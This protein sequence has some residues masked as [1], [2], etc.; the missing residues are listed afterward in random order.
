[1]HRVWG[2]I[3]F[4]SLL[5]PISNLGQC[6][7]NVPI[8]NVDL[9]GTPDSVWTSPP[10]ARDGHCCG[11]AGNDRCIDFVV[12]LDPNAAGIS[13]D[14]ISGAVPGGALFYQVNCG[15]PTPVG[16]P[17]CLNGPGPHI[18]TF[19]KPGN[20]TNVYQINSIPGPVAGT[21]ITIND[22]CS[23]TLVA[24]GFEESTA[25]WNSIYPGSSGQ[26]NNYLSC[27][28]GCL[29]PTVTATGSN[30]P[31]Y[32]DYVVCGLPESECAS[33]TVCDTVRVTFNPSLAVNITP[34]DPVICFGAT[35]TTITAN[36]SGGT[37][38]Y[39]YLWNNV[40]PS[41]T[42]IVGAGTYTVQ[43]SDASGC[44]PTFA[45]VTVTTYANPIS[46]NAGPN[47]TLCIQS[48]LAS[49]N[50]SVISATGGV[51]S[52]G[53]GIFSPNDS[54]LTNLTYTP[55]TS[56]LNNG[57]V[58]LFLTTTGNGG[59][60]GDVD[61]VRISFLN[62]TGIPSISSTN[63]SCY[64][65][66]D[67][68]ATINV[69]G[70][71]TPYTYQWN[72]VPT[73][74]TQTISS[75]SAGDYSVTVTDGIGCTITDSTLIT[76]PLPLNSTSTS[77]DVTCFGGSDGTITTTSSGGTT[78]YSYLWSPGGQTTNSLSGLTAGNYSYTVTDTNGCSFQVFD[79]INQPLQ[80]TIT[81][82][83]TNVSC[84][85][86]SDG[87][88]T[89][90][91]NNPSGTYTYSWSPSG[92]NSSTASGLTAGTYTV[93][94]TSSFG[95]VITNTVTITE[96]AT[97]VSA[98]ISSTDVTCYNGNNGSATVTPSGG[99]SPYNYLW[100]GGQTTA[101]I[102]NLIAGTYNYQVTDTNGCS[103]S[104][105]VTITQPNQLIVSIS[106]QPVKCFGGSDGQAISY[107]SG[108]VAPYT[109]SWSPG[110]QT[111]ANLLNVT[112]GTYN[113]T[114]TDNN[115]CTA[116][117]TIQV[118]EPAAPLNTILT[119]TSTTCYGGNDGTITTGTTG[120]TAPYS[121]QWL[122]NGETTP[123]IM[124]DSGIYNVMITDS[125]G[126]TFNQ[127]A[128]ITQPTPV[129]VTFTT[130]NVSCYGGFDGSITATGGGGSSVYSYSW[131]QLGDTVQT[132]TG[133][134][135]GTYIVYVKDKKNCLAIDSVT[136]TQPAFPISQTTSSTPTSCF[137]SS[138]GTASVTPAGGTAAYT[139]LWSTGDI[140][141]TISG[142]PAGNY[143]VTITDANGCTSNDTATINQPNDL[144]IT[145]TNINNVSCFGGNDGSAS[146]SATGGTPNYSFSWSPN[147]NTSNTATGLSAGSYTVNVTDANGC[148][149]SNGINVTEPTVITTTY[150]VTNVSCFNGNNGIISTTPSGGTPPFTYSWMPG[151]LSG[152]TISGLTAG[153]YDL[154]LT[155][156]NGCIFTDIITITQPNQIILNSG[157]INSDCGQANGLAFVDVVSGGV[158]PF[159]YFWTPGNIANDTAN[160][161][162]SGTYNVTVTD[163]NGCNAYSVGNVNDNAAPLISITNTNVTCNGG[164][165]GT[166]S[167]SLT[168]GISP[169]TYS[170]SNGGATANINN[171]TAGIYYLTAGGANGCF[172]SDTITITEPT[173]ITASITTTGTLCNGDN[174]GTAT[175]TSYGG[176][177]GYSYSW[178]GSV[179]TTNSAA[180]LSA[181]SQNVTITDNSGCSIV[182]NFTITE[183]AILTTTT[184]TTDVSCFG[185]S[186][187][188]ATTVPS[189]GTGPY[190]FFWPTNNVNYATISNVPPGSYSVNITD[191]N[192]C[193]TSDNITINQPNQISLSI[194]TVNSTCGQANGQATVT[195]TGGTGGY[196][197][198]WIPSGGTAS[199]ETGLLSG[200]YTV[201]VFD[202]NNCISTS[203][204]TVNNIAG[205][206]T[207][208][209][210]T[211][212]V[213]CYGGSNGSATATP[214]GGTSPFTYLWSNG[215]TTATASSLSFGT[216]SVTVTDNNGCTSNSTTPL[217]NE[218]DSLILN[219]VTLPVS[220]YNGNDGSASATA[221][222]GTPGYSYSWSPSGST[223]TNISGISAGT[224]TVQVTD[225]K[226]CQTSSSFTITQ[227]SALGI[228][229][230]VTTD[231]NCLGGHDGTATV[232]V[233]GGTPLY[234]YNWAP[235][236][237]SGSTST[238][239]TA[240]NYTVTIT[241]QK[242][243]TITSSAT[244]NEP[245][246]AISATISLVPNSCAGGSNG[247]ATVTPSGGT[248]GYTYIWSISGASG[249]TASNLA[250]G[251]YSVAVYDTNN[252]RSNL[253]FNI[254]EPPGLVAS[255]QVTPPSCSL[256][257]GQLLAQVS[258]GTP[259]YIFNWSNSGS[260]SSVTGLAPG[261]YS[262]DITDNAGCSLTLDTT[263]INIP[264]PTMSLLS[265]TE[266]SCFGSNDG[267]AEVTLTNGTAPFTY[268]WSPF[269]GNSSVGNNL[270]AGIYS[271]V[272]TDSLNCSDTLNV[273]I[274]Q[275]SLLNVYINSIQDISCNGY[276][277]GS[278]T[279]GVSGGTSSYS[280]NWS[281]GS[282]TPNTLNN[283]TSG[284]YSVIVTDN[285]NC[286]DSIPFTINEPTP[287]VALVDSLIPTTCNGSQDGY[288]YVLTSGGTLP[289]SY[290]WSNGGTGNSISNISAGTY[291]TN[292]TDGNG[293]TT[294]ISANVTE[295]S[296]II[297][298]IVGN[299]T[300]CQGGLGTLSA[301]ATGGAGNYSFAWQPTAVVNSG[302]YSATPTSTTNYTV[303]AYDVNGCPGTIDTATIYV[304]SLGPE[305]IQAQ[306]Y[307]PICPGQSTVVYVQT[308]NTGDSLL[309]TWNN[310]LGTGMGGFVVE[311]TVPTSYVVTVSNLC[312]TSIT[313]TVDV[314]FNDPP[315]I[316]LGSDITNGCVPIS[317]HFT[318]SSYS[319][320]PLDPIVSWEWSFGD[321]TLSNIQNPSHDYNIAG[322]YPVT[323]TVTTLGGCTNNNSSTPY[324]I[325]AYP[326][327]IANFT[328]N[329]N[330][331]NIPLDLLECTN[332]SVGGDS[333]YWNFGD[334]QTSEDEN[335]THNYTSIGTFN[336]ELVTV[337]QY[338]CSDTTETIIITGSDLIFPNAF[339][340]N[341]DGSSG[342]Y[343]D[344]TSLNND[345]FFPYTSGV[346]EYKLQIFNR[347]GE[348]IFESDD[349]YKGW[350][351]YYRGKLVQQ[352]VYVW[353]AYVRLNTGKVYN[354]IGDVTVLR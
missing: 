244:I 220:C 237:G 314:V 186:N 12:T 20:N 252:C 29:S 243:C 164:N 107:T 267:S 265:S 269:G 222:G 67:G 331:L 256:N 15:P 130:T 112:A 185:G 18:I 345:I 126:C 142:Q 352:D 258:G 251:T 286:K 257:N 151:N 3:L 288:I 23:Q 99:T 162:F 131:P 51:W 80:A 284:S 291:N 62:F 28:S 132:V 106:Q 95:C 201:N 122:P 157:A 7:P 72:T 104:G 46:A 83:S 308:Y 213:S 53:N 8:F 285:H 124:G 332:T 61:T 118:T 259:S 6:G 300:I 40:N 260:N 156:S 167:A 278:I 277:D 54:S 155:D 153:T 230:I 224:G 248:P 91:I 298:S 139:Y 169:Y 13:L 41:Q 349:V 30:I 166:A 276:N 335:P 223:G 68:S 334:G 129:T 161:L 33:I 240:G 209:T 207:S 305:N 309:F 172:S 31:T 35:S 330:T 115:G 337:N 65:L 333:F 127:T 274:S 148:T 75:L 143:P 59:C 254:L 253:S 342:G 50:G 199:T 275:P 16:E 208:I 178:S 336:V 297:T 136:I 76:Q 221:H 56:E 74:T 108:G 190:S 210:A 339:T 176:N 189:G 181:G 262:V 37:P 60:P 57:F 25:S 94:A 86:G 52:G 327:P 177:P 170:W 63:I 135:A 100:A 313:D 103:T 70:G 302:L 324:L 26:Y 226:G 89:A 32:I 96:P 344:V 48:P 69:S 343:Y 340:P 10:V 149:T 203:S 165:N 242:G 296:P 97:P 4:F 215:E 114:V 235:S 2:V 1:M 188:T 173:A 141:N 263:L 346:V 116:L 232:S 44:P 144:V 329:S 348:L 249:P 320:N 174:N 268:N 301:Y 315:T 119:A 88:A 191:A 121:Y 102:S 182:S 109:Y 120:G 311:P 246:T 295:P 21:D 5:I 245:S 34:I 283:L 11:G 195:A 239:L 150:S 350:D 64:G 231:V 183:P 255:L 123:S 204:V 341:S 197:Y 217:I 247:S 24:S 202:A 234:T 323:L 236:G 227:P 38:P 9:T 270:Y 138:D 58:D 351:G 45:T 211:S 159:T 238:S 287:L 194:S 198:S 128:V 92:G 42:N 353:K 101:S 206:T 66:S 321:N 90:T 293:C 140:T 205:P 168:G 19:C 171:L 81:I 98:T 307:S 228:N 272:V 134:S 39:S 292:I 71:I 325:E 133:L 73:Q 354:E 49:L 273:T 82:T 318:D 110:G 175:V 47:D 312:G 111:S 180:N 281:N 85:G 78:P 338:G 319:S 216:Y 14:I 137:G 196:T 326:I 27:T 310:G 36:G 179:S 84:F 105:F 229:S 290:L 317:V 306:A 250:Q 93:T 218:P 145:T 304:Y 261:N 233:S 154:T 125:N 279:V 200:N 147:S 294:T 79:T 77:T 214:T 43:M 163:A 303:V 264:G 193:T 347:W 55:T 17:I 146:V 289:Y 316:V 184:T 22:G 322:S 192:G 152:S 212:N 187:G 219:I 87:T 158:G 225:S 271:V 280:F 113:L 117:S 299:D 266:A 241:D 328:V 282:S 160:N